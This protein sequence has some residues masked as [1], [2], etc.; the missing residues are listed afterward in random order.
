[1]PLLSRVS[2]LLILTAWVCMYLPFTLARSGIYILALSAIP[3]SFALVLREP[4]FLFGTGL[5]IWALI[6]LSKTKSISRA[7]ELP[8]YLLTIA[9]YTFYLMLY[10]YS[11][12]CWFVLQKTA[13]TYSSAV[14]ALANNEM[15]LGPTAAGIPITVSMLCYSFGLIYYRRKAGFAL[16]ALFTPL[17]ANAAFLCLQQPLVDL[18]HLFDKTLQPTPLNLQAILLLVSAAAFYPLSRKMEFNEIH[19]GILHE[20]RLKAAAAVILVFV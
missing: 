8:V 6:I 9:G 10:K 18:V 19:S 2:G 3:V 13:L 17:L 7:R 5:C 14:T 1:M 15:T 16:A 11:P 20:E 12:Y 4:T